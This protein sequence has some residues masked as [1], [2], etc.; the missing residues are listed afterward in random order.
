[1]PLEPIRHPS[2]DP[3]RRAPVALRAG[4]L[5]LLAI[6]ATSLFW[7]WTRGS[8]ARTL[9]RMPAAERARL[10]Q[11]TRDKA[12]ALCAD[13]NLEDLCREEVDLLSK[14]PECDAECRS[15]VARNHPPASR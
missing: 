7:G 3:R 13:R 1:M 10:F 15:F 14:F 9:A 5:L 11:L 6:A 12:Q 8:D 2:P 4:L